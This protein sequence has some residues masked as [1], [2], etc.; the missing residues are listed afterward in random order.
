MAK[1]ILSEFG[2][3][4]G[5]GQK[6]RATEGGCCEARD[7]HNYSSPQGPT[8]QMRQGPGLGGTNHGTSGTQGSHSTNERQSGRPGLGGSN[9]GNR[10]QQRRR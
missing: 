1:D 10:G 5:T 2:Q 3:D 8:K 4:S 6:P 9:L 7:V